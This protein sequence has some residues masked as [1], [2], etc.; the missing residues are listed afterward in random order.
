[1]SVS[2]D[3]SD[4]NIQA[5]VCYTKKLHV[6]ANVTR[7]YISRPNDVAVV[8]LLKSILKDLF[9]T[10]MWNCNEIERS[11]QFLSYQKLQTE[12]TLLVNNATRTVIQ[13]AVKFPNSNIAIDSLKL[14]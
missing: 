3:I 14:H 5:K 6:V 2:K 8:Y 7:K 9:N 4:F 13:S 1:M 10:E 11:F 12:Q